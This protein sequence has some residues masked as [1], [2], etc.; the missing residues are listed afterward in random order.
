MRREH[1]NASLVTCKAL[2]HR[3]VRWK[4]PFGNPPIEFHENWSLETPG[5][6][7]EDRG[8]GDGDGTKYTVLLITTR[9]NVDAQFMRCPCTPQC[10]TNIASGICSSLSRFR[11]GYMG[12][13]WHPPRASKVAAGVVIVVAGTIIAV[14]GTY[15]SVSKI[16][17]PS[18]LLCH[19]TIRLLV[20]N[21]C[22]QPCFVLER[23]NLLSRKCSNYLLLA[24]WLTSLASAFKLD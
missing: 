8:G 9:K 1:A 24:L 7:G 23:T 6:A 18:K 21:S 10:S 11:A 12:E 14:F 5:A 19:L 13:S 2:M 22:V 16:S 15:S 4:M 20:F 17:I 3:P